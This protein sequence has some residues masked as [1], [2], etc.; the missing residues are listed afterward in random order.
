MP[1]RKSLVLGLVLCLA[2]CPTGLPPV[3]AGADDKRRNRQPRP[4]T[5]LAN[6]SGLPPTVSD[7][8]PETQLLGIFTA[9]EANRLGD[10]LQLTE[11]LLRQ[12]P[13]YRLAHLIKGDLLLARARPIDSFGA[14]SDAPADK[15][16][17]LR[18]E[19]IV[20]LKAYRER[21]EDNFV[22]RYLLQMQP[23]QRFAV[24]VDTQRSRLYLYENDS[25]QRRPPALRR[26]LLCYPGQ[27]GRRQVCRGRQ[28]DADRR[29]SRHR[30]PAP[31]EAGRSLRQRRLPDQL[32][33]RMGPP[34]RARRQRHLA[35]RHAF[36]HLRPPAERPPTAASC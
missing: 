23:D 7:S 3:H 4:A 36:R 32:P 16:A 5:T 29:L 9:I 24:V 12:H 11:A 17:D 1:S 21:P 34:A 8:G 27:A 13:N 30:Q 31:A 28:E 26:R 25:R 18:A 20:R 10:A 19:A 14:A 15:V 33:E 35:A 6:A 22:P 2:G